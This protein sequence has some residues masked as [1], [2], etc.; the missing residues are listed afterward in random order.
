[1]PP[2]VV[3]VLAV[4]VGIVIVCALTFVSI[5]NKRLQNFI[6]QFEEVPEIKRGRENNFERGA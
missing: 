5:R 4:I 2:E 1:M 3:I 6:Q